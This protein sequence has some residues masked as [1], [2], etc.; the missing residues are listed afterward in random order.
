[1]QE[2]SDQQVTLFRMK[3]FSYQSN[4]PS[5]V[6]DILMDKVNDAAADEKN[7]DSGVESGNISDSTGNNIHT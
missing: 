1:M 7:E 6:S 2:S 3:Q 5:V 4:L